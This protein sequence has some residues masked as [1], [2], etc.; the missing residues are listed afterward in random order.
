MHFDEFIPHAEQILVARPG[1]LLHDIV[2]DRVA[3]PARR[4][5]HN[6]AY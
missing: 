4:C 5:D 6:R 1:R 3:D 2:E